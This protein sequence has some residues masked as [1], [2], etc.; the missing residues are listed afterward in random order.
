MKTIEQ[1]IFVIDVSNTELLFKIY[2]EQI[3]RQ[4]ATPN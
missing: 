3:M 1:K 2:K 4:Q